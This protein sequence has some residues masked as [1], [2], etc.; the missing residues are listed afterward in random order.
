MALLFASSLLVLL[1]VCAY[2]V[3][4]EHGIRL[5]LEELRAGREAALRDEIE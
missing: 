2:R 4:L 1:L 3:G 5:A